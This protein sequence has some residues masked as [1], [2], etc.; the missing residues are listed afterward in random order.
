[1]DVGALLKTSFIVSAFG[2]FIA[3][4]LFVWYGSAIEPLFIVAIIAS[5]IFIVTAIYEVNSSNRIS[6][7]EKTLWTIGFLLANTIVG[8]IYLISGRKRVVAKRD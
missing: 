3:A 1:M 2:T 5:I 8:I 4:M 6:S 7:K